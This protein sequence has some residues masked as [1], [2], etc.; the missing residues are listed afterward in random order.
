MVTPLPAAL[1]RQPFTPED[2]RCWQLPPAVL[3]RAALHTPTRGV[4]VAEVPET[5]LARVDA[6]DVGLPKD[7]A[8]SHVTAAQ[9]WDLPLPRGLED[10]QILDVMRATGLPQTRRLGCH[11]RR[12]SENRS[13]WAVHGIRVIGLADTWCDLGELA[14]GPDPTMDLDDLVIVGDAIVRRLDESAIALQEGV[15]FEA[16]ATCQ[17]LWPRPGD[18]G[19]AE[20]MALLARESAGSVG[21]AELR[22]AL[23]AR[24]RPRGRKVLAEAL[25]LVRPRV[26]SPMETR[27]R[28]MFLRAGFPEPFV[29]EE[30]RDEIGSFLL[31][32]DLVW[33]AQRVVGEYQG[34]HHASIKRRSADSNRASVAEDHDWTVLEI[35]SEDVHQRP[36]RIACLT[37]F[38]RALTLDP[39]T[40]RIE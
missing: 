5:I 13:I 16:A 25:A 3:R 37:R 26:K 11:G 39:A 4:R 20:L 12:G 6:F 27:S 30:I 8:F 31:E 28:L 24:V 2:V 14:T 29:N 23:S 7:A 21:M 32:G 36:R 1:L 9:L 10:R 38:A 17:E 15:E 22:R 34:E 18:P 19:R 40:L 33:R 35:F